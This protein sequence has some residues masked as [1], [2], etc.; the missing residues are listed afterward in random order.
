MP[1]PVPLN[2]PAVNY[3]DKGHTLGA[4]TTGYIFI[5]FLL[6]LMIKCCVGNKLDVT[7]IRQNRDLNI[8]S[9]GNSS[10]P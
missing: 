9:G 8:D 10:E 3:T 5:T 6:Q 4:E 2:V 1:S 7:E